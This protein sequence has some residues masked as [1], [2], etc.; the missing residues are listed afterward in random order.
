MLASLLSMIAVM[1]PVGDDIAVVHAE[2]VGKG[3]LRIWAHTALSTGNAPAVYASGKSK[4]R[5]FGNRPV[6]AMF[7]ADIDGDELDEV[8]ILREE[9]D[10]GGRY[11]LSVHRAP[12]DFGDNVGKSI[13]TSAKNELGSADLF[14]AIVAMGAVDLDGDGV[15]EMALVREVSDGTQRLEV[16]RL[17]SGKKDD[18]GDTLASYLFIGKAPFDRVVAID[19]IDLNGFGLEQ[20]AVVR[21][22]VLGVR[23]LEI[24]RTPAVVADVLGAPLYQTPDPEPVLGVIKGVET[25]DT[26]ADGIDEL[27]VVRSSGD[28]VR[29][30]AY[31]VPPWGPLG[32]PKAETTFGTFEADTAIHSLFALR[33]LTTKEPPEKFEVSDLVGAF[34]YLMTHEEGAGYSGSISVTLGPTA[35]ATGSLEGQSF[36]FDFGGDGPRI[37]G[38][39]VPSLMVAQ[40]DPTPAAFAGPEGKTYLVK[41]GPGNVVWTGEKV[42][43]VGSYA[44]TGKHAN[45]TTFTVFGGQ[46]SFSGTPE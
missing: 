44:G 21:E 5:A 33:G 4:H 26:D 18:L 46:Y 35:G 2:Q 19:G 40:F 7:G 16:R 42:V 20:I 38:P 3:K 36:A 29:V 41:F 13:A 31:E 28:I 8:V 43:I 6:R 24:M 27:G 15:D 34:D 32:I 14:G 23:K 9:L 12:Q 11:R 1:A 37:D 39:F 45:G 17:P 22:D 25:F 30:S 10:H